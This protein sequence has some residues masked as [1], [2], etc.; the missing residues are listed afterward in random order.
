MRCC[1][2]LGRSLCDLC[3]TKNFRI[4]DVMKYDVV[5]IGAGAAGMP[6]AVA[7]ARAGARTLLL[8][9]ESFPG[10]VAVPAM[11]QSICGLYLCGEDLPAETLNA[12]ITR[13]ICLRLQKLSTKTVPFRVGRTYVLPYVTGAVTSVF[14]DMISAE[15]NLDVSYNT[16]VVGLDMNGNQVAELITVN[17]DEHVSVESGVVIDCS[18]DGILLGLTDASCQIAPVSERQ[19]AGYTIMLD[20]LVKVNDTLRIKVPYFLM[21]AVESGLIPQYLRFATFIPGSVPSEGYCKLPL[22]PLEV[23]E[24]QERLMAAVADAQMVLEYLSDVLPEFAGASIINTSVNVMNREYRRLKGKCTLTEYDVLGACKVED[25]VARGAWPVEFWSQKTGPSYEYLAS[26]SYYDIPSGCLQSDS[27][28]NLLCA[29][30][31]ISATPKA[32]ASCRVMGICFAT[33]EAAG[34]LATRDKL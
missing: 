29:G 25:S 31:C 12:G 7:A 33:G 26:S 11:H 10:G 27:V 3:V 20:G 5:V 8:E 13:E 17:A 4:S 24:D 32:L 15:K 19:S 6:A 23:V 1:R 16:P 34:L 14:A 22:P 28:A 18:G 2:L 9:K 21:R 30:R